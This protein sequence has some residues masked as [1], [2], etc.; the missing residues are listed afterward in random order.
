MT[1]FNFVVFGINNQ[2]FSTH[3]KEHSDHGNKLICMISLLGNDFHTVHILMYYNM[4]IAQVMVACQD[5]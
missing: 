3:K 5:Y 4:F 1:K 2:N